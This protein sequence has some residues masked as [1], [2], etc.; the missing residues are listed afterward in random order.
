MNCSCV[1]VYTDTHTC[2][3]CWTLLSDGHVIYY[4][5]RVF[6][7]V[8][9]AWVFVQF[10]L[11]QSFC[12]PL[13]FAVVTFLSCMLGTILPFYFS[14]GTPTKSITSMQLV[15]FLRSSPSILI[16]ELAFI[17]FFR[18][19]S[20]THSCFIILFIYNGAY[21]LHTE[22]LYNDHSIDL[23][24]ICKWIKKEKFTH[25]FT[26]SLRKRS[27][28]NRWKKKKSANRSSS[29]SSSNTKISENALTILVRII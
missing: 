6:V 15:V 20:F 4:Y 22:V 25:P 23:W 2:N 9:H 21:A 1:L 26:P 16:Y 18:S 29:S 7:C 24:I 27:N 10:S 19:G 28:R 5:I 13:L 12:H 3:I 8:W 11:S 14:I 17:Y